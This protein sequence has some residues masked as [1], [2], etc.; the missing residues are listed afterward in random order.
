MNLLAL[1]FFRGWQKVCDSARRFDTQR[2]E[3]LGVQSL[4]FLKQAEVL[5]SPKGGGHLSR[6]PLADCLH[7]EPGTPGEICLLP[8]K[9]IKGGSKLSR[10]KCPVVFWS[11]HGI[12]FCQWLDVAP[13]RSQTGL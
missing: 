4:Q 13:N 11:F 12:S 3:I 9:G 7:R 6:G 8:A 5:A 10:C 2:G 1:F